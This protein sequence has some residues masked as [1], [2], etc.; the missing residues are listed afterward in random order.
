[1]DPT[2]GHE[3]DAALQSLISA[4]LAMR[5]GDAIVLYRPEFASIE[6]RPESRAVFEALYAYWLRRD[7]ESVDDDILYD[8]V[9]FWQHWWNL[10]NE[11][12]VSEVSGPLRL[13]AVLV[14]DGTFTQR[15]WLK[16]FDTEIVAHIFEH[17]LMTGRAIVPPSTLDSPA[18]AL[19]DAGL[20]AGFGVR[21]FPAASM[22]LISDGSAAV[23]PEKTGDDG[24]EPQRLTK[25]PSVVE[26]LQQ[27]FE[28]QWA[29]AVPWAEYKKGTTGI[30][31]LLARGW[32]D[33][34]IA[35]A[36]DISPRT[37]SRRVTKAMEAADV[38]S[39]FELGMKYAQL[40]LGALPD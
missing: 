21:V 39:R 34:R 22:F 36:L 15:A 13:D 23:L 26:P 19:I 11:R 18:E 14:D 6:L 40:E 17:N 2:W 16:E 8:E 12:A 33:S 10:I 27:L 29:A 1:M 7:D 31:E 4:G 5:E 37:V 30:L 38:H 9:G 20:Y 25:R 3:Q 24:P 28:L 32:T 35:E